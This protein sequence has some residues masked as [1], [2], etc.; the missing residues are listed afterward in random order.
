MTKFQW[1]ECELTNGSAIMILF[2]QAMHQE[3]K[4]WWLILDLICPCIQLMT[5]QKMAQN[6]KRNSVFLKCPVQK[7]V[8]FWQ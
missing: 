8:A 5:A 4:M 2:S 1:K 3:P 7:N 6:K